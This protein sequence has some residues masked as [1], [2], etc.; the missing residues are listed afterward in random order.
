MSGTAPYWIGPLGEGAPGAGLG[1][2]RS[3]ARRAGSRKPARDPAR[4][5]RRARVFPGRRDRQG[6]SGAI[7]RRMAWMPRRGRDDLAEGGRPRSRGGG[8]DFRS[9]TPS[10]RWSGRP[11]S[12][13]SAPIG[14]RAPPEGPGPTLHGGQEFRQARRHRRPR[15]TPAIFMELDM[16]LALV[17]AALA[18]GRAGLEERPGDVGVIL[19]LAAHDPDSRG[20]RRRRSPGTAG[21]TDELGHVLLAEVVVGRRRCRPGAVDRASTVAGST[22]ARRRRCAGH[23]RELLA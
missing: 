23:V 22:P 6:P 19:G 21:R 1:P 9:N 7:R 2:S 16:V 15:H 4:E 18:G 10:R 8:A 13:R 5:L 20:C 14:R 12:G 11:A 17:A 3:D